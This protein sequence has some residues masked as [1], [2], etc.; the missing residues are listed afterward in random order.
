MTRTS[1]YGGLATGLALLL[2][3]AVAGCADPLAPELDRLRQAERRWAA[4][5]PPS[6]AYTFTNRCYCPLAEL[7]VVVE[8]G[9]VVSVESTGDPSIDPRDAGGYT[10]EELFERIRQ[11]IAREPHEVRASFHEGLGYPISVWFDYE[12]HAIDEE[13]GFEVTGFDPAD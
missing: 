6:Y 11:E 8:N 1:R 10:V 7:R 3:A 12:E 9:A 5:G 4:A 13:W 2:A